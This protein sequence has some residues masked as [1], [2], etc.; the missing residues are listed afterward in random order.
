[1]EIWSIYIPNKYVLIPLKKEPKKKKRQS[2][3]DQSQQDQGFD[4]ERK[5]DGPNM[6]WG[7]VLM[8]SSVYNVKDLVEA[9]NIDPDGTG[10]ALKWKEVQRQETNTSIGIVGVPRGF[11]VEGI[12]V[13]VLHSL[14]QIEKTLCTGGR[15]SMDL[16]YSP[17][18]LFGD[19][20]NRQ[21]ISVRA[22][23]RRRNT[24]STDWQSIGRM[25]V[26]SCT[27]SRILLSMDVW[28]SYGTCF[29]PQVHVHA[30]VG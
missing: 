12:N 24:H 23:E 21:G 1:M 10:V 3:Q 8:V 7:R 17:F 20:G 2:Q 14:K 6:V 22:L 28:G 13:V 5:Y 30:C 16:Y 4:K 18:L 29:I 11:C 25:V 26:K 15:R 19:T 9:L 27:L